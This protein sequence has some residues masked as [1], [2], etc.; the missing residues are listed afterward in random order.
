VNELYRPSYRR[1][2]A[3]LVSSLCGQRV[4]HGQRDGSLR[5]Y[6]RISRPE[7]LLLLPS[8]SSVVLTRLSGPRSRPI[9]QKNMIAPAPLSPVKILR[10]PRVAGHFW[11]IEWLLS[12]EGLDY[13]ELSCNL[14]FW[15]L[16]VMLRIMAGKGLRWDP[17]PPKQRQYPFLN[18]YLPGTPY[19]YPRL[20]INMT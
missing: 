4:L 5:P 16:D 20:I 1:L 7:P 13:S 12:H 11:P 8:S 10:V 9:T 18:N 19:I 15:I 6:S 3:K 17:N 2:S 14:A